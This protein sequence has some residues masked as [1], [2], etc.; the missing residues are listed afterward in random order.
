V[1]R[2]FEVDLQYLHE[3]LEELVDGVFADIQSQ[4]LVL[5]RGT[6]FV[7]YSDFQ[8]AYEV[9]KRRTNSFED[10]NPDTIWASLR[11]DAL[12][13]GVVRTILGMSPPEWADLARTEFNSDITQGYARNL[14]GRCRRDRTVFARM[15]H[16]GTTTRVFLGFR[17]SLL[18]P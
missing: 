5:P 17:L 13:F 14:D 15:G 18:L 6:V 7:E 9:L 16:Q 8:G 12:C 2:P 4:F 10:F 1:P 3:H 11:E